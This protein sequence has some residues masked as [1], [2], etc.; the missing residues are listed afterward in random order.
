MMEDDDEEL[1]QETH[2]DNITSLLQECLI[3]VN[4]DW[5]DDQDAYQDQ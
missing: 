3:D 2:R 1:M 5:K 4:L